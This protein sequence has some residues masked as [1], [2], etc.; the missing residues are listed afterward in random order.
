MLPGQRVRRQVERRSLPAAPCDLDAGS[1]LHRSRLA[2]CLPGRHGDDGG[3]LS[4]LVATIVGPALLV[5]LGPNV[6]RWRVGSPPSEESSRLMA[7]VNAALRR[8][9]AVA[10]LIGAVV[11]VLAA[12]AVALKT[13]PPS[14]EQLAQNASGPPKR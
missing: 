12:P 10:A 8:P 13:G 7:F 2:A 14:Q 9:A 11:L 1:A 4:V 5:L 6:D 3:A